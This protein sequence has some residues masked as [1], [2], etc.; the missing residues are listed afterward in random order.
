MEW[1]QSVAPAIQWSIPLITASSGAQTDAT[2]VYCDGRR[3]FLRREAMRLEGTEAERPLWLTSA[4]FHDDRFR[5]VNE[6]NE[7]KR[8]MMWTLCMLKELL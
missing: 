4:V 2:G 5:G 8:S 7:E 3:Y 6:Y 1:D